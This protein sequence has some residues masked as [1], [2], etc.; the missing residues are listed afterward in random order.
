MAHSA[1]HIANVIL[2]KFGGQGL[3]PMKLLKLTYLAQGWMLGLYNKPLIVD[4][5]E[6][7]KYGP[8]YRDVYRHVAGKSVVQNS[9]PSRDGQPLDQQEAHLID[10][11]H[12]IYGPMNGLQ[13]STLTHKSGSPWD[14]TYRKHGQN[15]VIPKSLMQDYYG[16]SASE[17]N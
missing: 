5:A 1:L 11:I 13:L 2:L 12:K 8:V 10:Q 14:V 3:G 17:R 7:W 4:D 15:A 6:A 16:K 9:L